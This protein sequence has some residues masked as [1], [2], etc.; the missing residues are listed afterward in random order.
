M[1]NITALL[2]LS[3]SRS[4]LLANMQLQMPNRARTAQLAPTA[5][6][7]QLANTASQP[8]LSLARTA[9]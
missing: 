1:T 7:A 8:T 3:L 6:L 5:G 2:A 9:S 4:A